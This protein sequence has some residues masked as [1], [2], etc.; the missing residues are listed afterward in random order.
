LIYL[1]FVDPSLHCRIHKAETLPPVSAFSFGLEKSWF[2][3]GGTCAAVAVRH[4]LFQSKIAPARLEAHSLGHNTLF[5]RAMRTTGLLAR[6]IWLSGVFCLSQSALSDV[7]RHL[8]ETQ[9]NTQPEKSLVA[10]RDALRALPAPS[11]ERAL[12]YL[13][14]A[15]ACR[16]LADWR[17]QQS[18]AQAAKRDAV[19]ANAHEANIRAGIVE[20]RASAALRDFVRAEQLLSESELLLKQHPN[21]VLQAD[22]ALAYSSLS[23]MLG[24][25]QASADYAE[26]ALES[27]MNIDTGGR[28][29]LLRNSARARIQLGDVAIAKNQLNQALAMA[30]ED[31]DPKLL[32][33]IYLEMARAARLLKDYPTQLKAA[34]RAEEIS[35]LLENSQLFGQAKEAEA[36]AYLDQSR[37]REAL[38]RFQQAAESFRNLNLRRDELRVL[39]Q[40]LP[41]MIRDAVPRAELEESMQRWIALEAE[42]AGS[43]RAQAAADFDVRLKSLQSEIEITR[44]ELEKTIAEERTE[45]SIQAASFAKVLAAIGILASVVLAWFWQLQRRARLRVQASERRLRAVA[46]NLPA[47]VAH[48]D[49]QQIIIYANP[50]LSRALSSTAEEVIGRSLGEV[51]APEHYERLGPFVAAAL[52]G[53]R[54]VV[55]DHIDLTDDRRYF[56]STLVPDRNASSE[57]R[58]V[59]LLDLDI[60]ELRKAQ[61]SLERMAHIDGLTGLANRQHFDG[62]LKAALARAKLQGTSVVLLLIDLDGFKPIN[63]QWGHLTG[64][65]ALKEA[66]RRL[67][68][69]V[70]KNDVVARFGGDEF[71]ILFE[72]HGGLEAGEAVAQKLLAQFEI[73]FRFEGK[74]IRLRASI[75]VAASRSEIEAAQ[76]IQA[77]DEALYR[78]KAEGKHTYRISRRSA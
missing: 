62:L 24:K 35:A 30:A 71:V 56:Q 29:R 15:N 10:I 1:Q 75:G 34:Q 23:W 33:E 46:E 32:G 77:A 5:I 14:E 61:L 66:A 42:V 50:E 65:A 39:S 43:D 70:R 48:L 20:G 12:L 47:A 3:F 55:D 18:A 2:P 21:D 52:K 4:Q 38:A 41:L 22:L 16:V 76:L 36:Q 78:A 27:K 49:S 40:L 64:D 11:E 57:V 63:D 69:T 72:G 7:K 45:K 60:T 59:F 6:T 74:S 17:C 44:L 68:L 19:D 58:G 31:S 54:L 51:L 28:I 53:E 8:L 73:G 13:A 67:R 26:A 9:A 37:D 25:V